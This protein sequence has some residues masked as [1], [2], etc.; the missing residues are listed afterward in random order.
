D[1]DRP[2]RG[3]AQPRHEVEQ[4]RLAGAVRSDDSEKLTWGQ[5]EVDI[6]HNGDSA[7][8]PGE[9]SQ[10]ECC[11]PLNGVA[12]RATSSG[13]TAFATSA[14]KSVP[15]PVS[16]AWNIGWRSAWSAARIV[17]LPL[18]LSKVQPSSDFTIASTSV[19]LAVSACTIICAAVKPSGWNRSDGAP[20]ALS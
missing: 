2:S 10:S 13:E 7:H 20:R 6:V 12:G 11:H 15:L 19:P 17:A 9:S 18:T 1:R 16:L 14:L 5:V 3:S 8:P 4:R